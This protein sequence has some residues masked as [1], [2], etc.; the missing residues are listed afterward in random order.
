[1]PT[2]RVETG[3][4]EMAAVDARSDARIRLCNARDMKDS[5]GVRFADV[6]GKEMAPGEG[7]T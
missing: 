3:V 4:W 6:I 5:G 1:V 2:C 7:P